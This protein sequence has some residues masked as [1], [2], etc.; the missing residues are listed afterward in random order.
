MLGEALGDGLLT[1]VTLNP[2]GDA[3]GDGLAVVCGKLKLDTGELESFPPVTFL[4]SCVCPSVI[5]GIGFMF[6]AV[7]WAEATSEFPP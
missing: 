4:K 2:P 7:V 5:S 1:G 6:P 3:D